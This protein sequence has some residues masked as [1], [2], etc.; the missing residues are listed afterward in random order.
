VFFKGQMD[1]VFVCNYAM[2]PEEMHKIYNKGSVALGASPKNA[3]DH[4]ES[5][6]STNL[7]CIFD[8]LEGQNQVSLAVA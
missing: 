3:G 5:M 7:Y 8:T 1:S 4:V 2:S 6:T